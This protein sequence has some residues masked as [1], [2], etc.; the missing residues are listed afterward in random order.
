MAV[1]DRGH[2]G[3]S[4]GRFCGGVGHEG[5]T[6]RL[7]EREQGRRRKRMERG[8]TKKEKKAKAVNFPF[9]FILIS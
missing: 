2:K 6:C 3:A 8:D 9:V 1:F 7:G 4:F 5:C